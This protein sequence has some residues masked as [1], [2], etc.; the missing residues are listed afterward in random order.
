M[1]NY[2]YYIKPGENF[3]NDL[4][5]IIEKIFSNKD[6]EKLRKFGGRIQISLTAPYT[7]RKKQRQEFIVNDEYIQRF[8]NNIEFAK[9]EITSLKMSQIKELAKILNF[10]ISSKT[11]IQEA[12]KYLFE[13]LAS[14]TK[15]QS[16]SN[17]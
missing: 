2:N 3:P 5:Q 17:K 16:I 1:P 10:P 4:T 11:T 15:W 8:K 12:K 9:S 13:F 14:D 6:I 7:D